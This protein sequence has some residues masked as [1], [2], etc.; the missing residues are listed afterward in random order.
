MKST[1]EIITPEFKLFGDVV[2]LQPMSLH[3]GKIIIPEGASPV[4]ETV[5]LCVA[6]IGDGEAVKKLEK[7][8]KVM[9]VHPQ[10]KVLKLDGNEYLLVGLDNILGVFTDY[11]S[12]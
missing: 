3:N 2:L 10:G 9:L 5:D 6:A 8:D 11:Q 1:T 4:S 7:G 12:A